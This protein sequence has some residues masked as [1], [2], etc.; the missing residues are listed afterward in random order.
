MSLPAASPR[1]HK[2]TRTIVCEGF[3]R[4]DGLFDVDA[5][6]VDVKTFDV[7]HIKRGRIPA[8]TR[9]HDMQ[10]RLTVDDKKVV[11]DIAV[12]PIKGRMPCVLRSH[13]RSASSSAHRSPRAGARP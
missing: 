2:H 9:I 3:E 1:K 7:D 13:P 5:S 8:G 10:L 12:S 6:I 4:E 11:R